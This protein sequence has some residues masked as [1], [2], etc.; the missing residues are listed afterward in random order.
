[1]KCPYCDKRVNDMPDHLNKTDECRRQHANSLMTQLEYILKI[2]KEK[3]KCKT[4]N[5]NITDC[6]CI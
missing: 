2:D 4:H 3:R 6:D 1:M 5:C